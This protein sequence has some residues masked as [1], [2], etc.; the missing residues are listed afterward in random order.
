MTGRPIYRVQPDGSGLA[1]LS[2]KTSSAGPPRVDATGTWVVYEVAGQVH[3]QRVDG[4]LEEVVGVGLPGGRADV[5]PGGGAVVWES[6]ADPSG[7]NP[8]GNVELFAIDRTTAPRIHVSSG[9]APT[10]VSWDVESGPLSCDVIRGSVASLA[11]SD[12]AVDLGTVVCVEDES[13]DASTADSPDS[14]EPSPQSK[15]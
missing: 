1:R 2:S 12:G 13:T 10:V 15:A 8:E 14:D 4:T 3:R 6:D 7:T 11:A 5:T 9:P